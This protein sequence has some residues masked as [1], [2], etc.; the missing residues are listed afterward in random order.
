MR[1]LFFL[2]LL[3][4]S[5]ASSAFAFDATGIKISS[6]AVTWEQL[7]ENQKQISNLQKQIDALH[8]A[9]MVAAVISVM[10][11]IYVKYSCSIAR[12]DKEIEL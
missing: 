6:G 3:F 10:S 2:I 9:C 4:Y 8:H 12:K 7:V 11:L 1:T 5:N